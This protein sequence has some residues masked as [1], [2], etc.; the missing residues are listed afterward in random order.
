MSVCTIDLA[1][2]IQ[3]QGLLVRNESP[4]TLAGSDLGFISNVTHL[5]YLLHCLDFWSHIVKIGKLGI[6]MIYRYLLSVL[7]VCISLSTHLDE[8]FIKVGSDP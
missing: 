3:H 7:R 4:S 1:R 5:G 2:H 8:H 6:N